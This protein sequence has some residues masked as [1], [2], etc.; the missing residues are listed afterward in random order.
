MYGT[1]NHFDVSI[2]GKKDKKERFFILKMRFRGKIS[3]S[4][5]VFTVDFFLII[6]K[7]DLPSGWRNFK[8]KI[9]IYS[10]SILQ[11]LY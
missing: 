5:H 9:K 6:K 7:I 4:L 10:K 11:Y 1:E 2:V 8:K 3:Y